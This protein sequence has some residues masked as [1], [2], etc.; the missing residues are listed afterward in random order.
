M[1]LSEKLIQLRKKKGLSQAELVR[2]MDVSRQAV[3][4]WEKGAATPTAENL[5][6]LSNIYGVPLSTL[7]DDEKELWEEDKEA[8]GPE[9]TAGENETPAQP[10]RKRSMRIAVLIL[11]LLLVISVA[12][13]VGIKKSRDIP[14][15]LENMENDTTWGNTPKGEFAVDW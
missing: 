9:K 10:V 14:V 4:K 11:I 5:A 1:D 3:A 2:M 13:Y 15:Q 6:R 12:I 7:L 8:Q